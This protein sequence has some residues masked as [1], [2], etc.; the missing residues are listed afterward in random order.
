MAKEFAKAF[1]KSKEWKKCR[2]SYI[3]SVFGL[4]E[5][6]GEPGYIAHHKIHITKDNINNPDIT[7]SHNNLEYLC[8]ECHNRHHN[9]DRGKERSTREGFKFNENGELVR[10]SPP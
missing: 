10:I 6:C 4:C 7:L 8:L 5:R 3:K 1:Y 2:E 9:F